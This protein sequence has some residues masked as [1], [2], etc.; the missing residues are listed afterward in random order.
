LIPAPLRTGKGVENHLSICLSS[1]DV[2]RKVHRQHAAGVFFRE[3][4]LALSAR[5]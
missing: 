5:A 3:L 1:V 2:I 4:N